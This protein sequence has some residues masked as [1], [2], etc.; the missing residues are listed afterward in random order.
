MRKGS[1]SHS[2]SS[3]LPFTH[4]CFTNPFVFWKS[5]PKRGQS[6]FA[7]PTSSRPCCGGVVASSERAHVPYQMV[8]QHLQLLDATDG[9]MD[10]DSP[11]LRAIAR[12]LDKVS[13]NPQ[14]Y[15]CLLY[16]SSSPRD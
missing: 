15:A 8:L 4:V 9:T 3:H 6:R 16:T 7:A 2:P 1:G 11:A 5:N 14:Y 10:G 13:R 12:T